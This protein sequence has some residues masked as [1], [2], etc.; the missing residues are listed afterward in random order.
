MVQ[1]ARVHAHFETKE[2]FKALVLLV[3][4]AVKEARIASPDVQVHQGGFSCRS[5]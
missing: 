1:L 2:G 3:F 5:L 4:P